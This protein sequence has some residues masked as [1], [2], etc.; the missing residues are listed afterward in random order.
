VSPE[1]RCEDTFHEPLEGSWACSGDRAEEGRPEMLLQTGA[2][3]RG[4][5]FL[6]TSFQAIVKRKAPRLRPVNPHSIGG[7][8]RGMRERNTARNEGA[9]RTIHG[10]ESIA[11]FAHF[12]P[13]HLRYGR[14][15]LCSN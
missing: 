12:L 8:G 7:R 4:T 14:Y 10:F 11:N 1:G 6:L 15:D 9:R 5:P 3:R 13:P 2:D